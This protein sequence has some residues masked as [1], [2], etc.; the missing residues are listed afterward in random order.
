MSDSTVVINGTTYILS[1]LRCKYLRQI[2]E[3]LA[4]GTLA[5]TKGIY[6]EIEKFMPYIAASIKEKV[7]TF[8]QAL[9]DE[10]TLQEFMDTWTQVVAISGIRVVPKEETAAVPVVQ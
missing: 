2:S 7:P 8:D 4:S 10:L 5:P 6:T 3:V 9:L 1:P